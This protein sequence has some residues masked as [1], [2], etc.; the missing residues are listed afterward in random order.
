MYIALFMIVCRLNG[1]ALSIYVRNGKRQDTT[2]CIFVCSVAHF[3]YEMTNLSF[4]FF[5][6]FEQFH[7]I[8][9]QLFSFF[10]LMF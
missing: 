1:D 8:A 9:K 3:C 4:L 7:Q 2:G 6:I 10:K 5:V